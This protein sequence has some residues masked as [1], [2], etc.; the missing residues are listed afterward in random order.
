[1]T[2]KNSPIQYSEKTLYENKIDP[3]SCF[4]IEMHHEN[5]KS[6]SWIEDTGQSNQEVFDFIIKMIRNGI[7]LQ[8]PDKNHQS[9]QRVFNFQIQAPQ[10]SPHNSHNG[11]IRNGMAISSPPYFSSDDGFIIGHTWPDSA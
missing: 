4:Q 10:K 3:K 11:E 1:M 2:Q 9:H 7:N 5:E 6:T 8:D